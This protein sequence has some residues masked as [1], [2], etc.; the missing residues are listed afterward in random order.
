M[1]SVKSV[2]MWPQNLPFRNV[3]GNNCMQCYRGEP[4]SVLMR[5]FFHKA[6]CL[7]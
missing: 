7:Y 5:Y 6:V 3:G 4:T 1:A 2:T